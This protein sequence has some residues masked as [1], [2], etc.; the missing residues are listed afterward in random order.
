[1]KKMSFEEFRNEMIR[2]NEEDAFS[3]KGKQRKLVGKIVFKASNWPNKNYSED[4]LTY[5]TT[6]D[7]K[8]FRHGCFSCSIFANCAAPYTDQ[9]VRLDWYMKPF[10]PNGWEVDYC[11]IIGEE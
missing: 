3:V 10:E 6:S 2:F 7:N 4:E 8:G 9:G 11:E 1:M 5:I